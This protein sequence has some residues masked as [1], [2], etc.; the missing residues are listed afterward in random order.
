MASNVVLASASRS[1]RDLLTHAG[2]ALA[3]CDAAGIDEAEVK[4]SLGAEGGSAI[5]V[6]ET[7]AELKATRVAPRHPGAL[8]IG[9]DQMLNCEGRW[10]DKPSDRASAAEQLLA[11]SG[12][13]HTLET[14]VCVV[15][16]GERLWHHNAVARM[17]MRPFGA[18]FV[19]GYLDAV[20]EAALSSVGCYQL[21]GRGVQL[22][23]RI[24]G[25]FFTVLGL[26]LLPLLGFL[27]AQG[28]VPE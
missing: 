26:P 21:E 14:A 9:G 11:L 6:A 22:F 8:I 7:L 2:V 3:A 27:R 5:Q 20:G 13:T 19:E 25:D 24:D 23:S 12:K 18:A 4:A 10:F 1:R 28:V 17:T 16:D 15:R